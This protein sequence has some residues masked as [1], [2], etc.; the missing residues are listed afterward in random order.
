MALVIRVRPGAVLQLTAPQRGALEV[1]YVA[2]SAAEAVTRG[3]VACVV[4]LPGQAPTLHIVG[5]AGVQ[6]LDGLWA[7]VRRERRG[8]GV[9]LAFE[10]VW[11]IEREEAVDEP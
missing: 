11:A 8:G 7:H 1:L 2:P 10:G 5:V 6:L 9:A 3:D 4:R